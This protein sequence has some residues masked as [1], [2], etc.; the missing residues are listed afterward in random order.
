MSEEHHRMS[1]CLREI[2]EGIFG[3]YAKSMIWKKSPMVFISQ[4]EAAWYCS[5]LFSYWEDRFSLLPERQSG[6]A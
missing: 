1:F 6:L 5:A 2:L 3:V 4:P